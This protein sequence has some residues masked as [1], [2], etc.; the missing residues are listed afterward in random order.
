M[1]ET[2]SKEKRAKIELSTGTIIDISE[3]EY[4]ELMEILEYMRGTQQPT[5]NSIWNGCQTSPYIIGN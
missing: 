5:P 2:T 3:A 1:E 4:Y